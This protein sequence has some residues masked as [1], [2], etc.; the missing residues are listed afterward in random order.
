MFFEL[1]N[2]D[3]E[4]VALNKSKVAVEF[5]SLWIDAKRRSETEEDGQDGSPV[6]LRKSWDELTPEDRLELLEAYQTIERIMRRHAEEEYARQASSPEALDAKIN[7][8]AQAEA[9]ITELNAEIAR[10]EA[11]LASALAT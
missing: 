9:R 10:K 2:Y 3:L 6:K 4:G 7:Q 11:Q 8:A 5:A 1:L